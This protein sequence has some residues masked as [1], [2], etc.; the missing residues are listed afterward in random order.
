MYAVVCSSISNQ[1]QACCSVSQRQPSRKPIH[2][3]SARACVR[4]IPKFS[5]QRPEGLVKIRASQVAQQVK[6]ACNGKDTGDMGSIPGSGRSLGGG[7]SNPLQY[8]YLENPMNR[9]ASTATVHGVVKS[10]TG[11]KQLST[12]THGTF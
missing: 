9:G 12:H 4:M 5:V 7:H 10:L 1:R 6:S 11:L 8:S 2:V 3:I